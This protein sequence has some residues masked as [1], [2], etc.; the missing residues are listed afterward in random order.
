MAAIINYIRTSLNDF[1]DY[2]RSPQEDII[3]S[4]KP[5]SILRSLC[6]AAVVSVSV[7]LAVLI[8]GILLFACFPD[9]INSKLIS[10]VSIYPW[11]IVIF[12]GPI[13]EELLCRL[14]LVRKKVFLVCSLIL[15]C[16]NLVSR[17]AYTGQ[18]YSID[19]IWA[20]IGIAIPAGAI[21]FLVSNKWLT[22]CNYR[23]YFY[24]WA[25][26]FGT[27]HLSRID[28]GTLLPLDYI[29]IILYVAK[30]SIMGLLWG[31]VRMKNGIVSSMLLHILNN[32]L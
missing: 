29:T 23:I 9:H 20:R 14:S 18:S 2:V 15:L 1:L 26:I 6:C 10:D 13:V 17:F 31:Y 28:F 32:A 5:H 12:L 30:Q 27:A 21:L 22:R 25:L 19:H 4:Y 8:I 16:F 3:I 7:V 24:G 11:W